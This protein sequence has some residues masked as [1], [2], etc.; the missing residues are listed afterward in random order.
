[1]WSANHSLSFRVHDTHGIREDVKNGLCQLVFLKFSYNLYPTHYLLHS[2]ALFIMSTRHFLSQKMDN[3]KYKKLRCMYWYRFYETLKNKS[4]GDHVCL[5]CCCCTVV[6]PV[7]RT[8]SFCWFCLTSRI[9]LYLIVIK[10]RFYYLIFI[11]WLL[12]PNIWGVVFMMEYFILRFNFYLL[13]CN[14]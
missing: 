4:T 9:V 7:S 5:F 1:M 11:S 13:L 14:V 8:L 2:P 10:S 6:R 12:V 3:G